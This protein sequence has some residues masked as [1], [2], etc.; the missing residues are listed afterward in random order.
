MPYLAK[1]VTEK[2]KRPRRAPLLGMYLLVYLEFNK[3]VM[4]ITAYSDLL[5]R[6]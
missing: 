5:I 3:A 6:K 4:Q 2:T 1:S